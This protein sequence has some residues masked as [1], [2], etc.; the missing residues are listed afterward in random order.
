M[1]EPT[2]RHIQEAYSF[3]CIVLEYLGEEQTSHIIRCIPEWNEVLTQYNNLRHMIDVLNGEDLHR[4]CR[5]IL[6]DDQLEDSEFMDEFIR[7][8][9]ELM[10]RY[11]SCFTPEY[12]ID[13][14]ALENSLPRFF[15]TDMTDIV[16]DFLAYEAHEYIEIEKPGY[17]YRIYNSL[18]LLEPLFGKTD[19]WYIVNS[20]YHNEIVMSDFE[21]NG[22]ASDWFDAFMREYAT[23]FNQ[24]WNLTTLIQ[25]TIV[26][27]KQ[28]TD[29]AYFILTIL[30]AGI[31]I[32]AQNLSSQHIHHLQFI[33]L[34][35]TFIQLIC[36]IAD[37][38]L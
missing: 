25:N 30:N 20:S 28:E 14:N 27:S 17:I 19:S 22:V 11:S 2:T 5:I 4:P 21:Q 23:E 10:Y 31:T 16:L 36:N 12:L 35:Q 29:Y 24:P 6:N 32:N 38:H 9:D 3:T 33:D 26:E 7:V 1:S 34:P 8:I 37:S 15:Y 13:R 18:Y